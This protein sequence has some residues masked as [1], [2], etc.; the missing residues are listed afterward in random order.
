MILSET[1]IV[2]IEKTGQSDILEILSLID[3]GIK[4]GIKTRTKNFVVNVSFPNEWFEVKSIRKVLEDNGY[5][6]LKKGE[7]SSLCLNTA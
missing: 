7:R 6:I 3:A 5:G 2:L 1:R 4:K